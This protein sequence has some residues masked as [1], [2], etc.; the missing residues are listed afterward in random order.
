MHWRRIGKPVWARVNPGA[1]IRFSP[2]TARIAPLI[3]SIILTGS[4]IPAQDTADEYRLGCDGKDAKIAI[5]ACT[6]LIDSGTERD[7][8]LAA[9]LKQRANA[10]SRKGDDDR[11]AADFHQ[12]IRLNPDDADPFYG[13]GL[14]AYRNRDY[15]EAVS[16]FA[17]A[18]WN[19]VNDA[20]LYAARGNAFYHL[21]DFQS[22]IADYT[23]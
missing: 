5:A 17:T 6:V 1:L 14:I 18:I 19:R 7:S 20:K 8:A 21:K 13:L 4:V 15:Q 22:A 9:D 23:Q 10:Y 16:Q 12:V 11:A 2:A 3:L